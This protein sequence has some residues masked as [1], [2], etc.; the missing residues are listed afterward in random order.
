MLKS[1]WKVYAAL[2]RLV[3]L[4]LV[5]VSGAGVMAMMLVTCADVAL[6]LPFI[7][8]PFAGAYDIVEMAGAITLAAALPYTTAVKGH[9]AIE[10]FFHRL[11]RPGRIVVDTVVRLIGMTLFAFLSWRSFVYGGE[12]HSSG[13]VSQTL[14]VPIFWIPYVIGVSCA[15]V[16]LVIFHNLVCPGREMVKL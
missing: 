11:N 14:Q 16:V 13:Q 3:V 4:G 5:V 8:R 6:R 2:L 15:V 7:Q 1:L 12:L 9:V 10:Y